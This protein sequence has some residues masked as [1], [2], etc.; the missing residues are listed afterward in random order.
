MIQAEG[1]GMLHSDVKRKAFEDLFGADYAGRFTDPVL[2]QPV[3]FYSPPVSQEYR[4]NF[5]V[6]SRNLFAEW[7]YRRRRGFNEEILDNYVKVSGNKLDGIQ[8][9][10]AADRDRLRAM[11]EGNG[12]EIDAGYLHCRNQ[13]APVIHSHAKEFLRCLQLFDE[14]LQITGSL[15]LHGM[16]SAVE[17]RKVEVRARAAIR[18]FSATIRNESVKMRKEA[19]RLVA[20]NEHDQE[21][22]ETMRSQEEA[23]RHAEA[24]LEADR[25]GIV[26]PDGED[27]VTA[28]ANAKTKAS[29]PAA[30][31]EPTA[32]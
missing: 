6:L 23:E 4:Q 17:R 31:S 21:L 24:Q 14:L 8:R 19:Q 11:A 3:T 26:L 12:I 15:A 7:V 30:T 1:Q 25:K 32:A 13:M 9:L 16:L 10:I 20:E 29:A 28:L 18:S 22:V 2:F 5:K 27:P